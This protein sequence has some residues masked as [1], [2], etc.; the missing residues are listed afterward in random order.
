M[1]L[2]EDAH[3]FQFW[4]G[5]SGFI[6]LLEVL[7]GL[8]SKN[9]QSKKL[10]GSR[11]IVLNFSK[12]LGKHDFGYYLGIFTKIANKKYKPNITFELD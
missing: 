5:N 2:I 11:I 3:L 10:Y 6:S 7:H 4:E 8:A 1:C 9:I 12:I